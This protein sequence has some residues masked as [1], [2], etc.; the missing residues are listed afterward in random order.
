MMVTPIKAECLS[1]LQGIS[2][3]FFTR[4]GGVSTGIY[5]G[6]N[7][8]FGSADTASA[9]AENRRR[10]AAHLLSEQRDANGANSPLTILTLHQVHS[11]MA[12]SVT[13]TFARD[14]LPKADGLVTATRG[15]VIGVLAA[16]CGPVLFADPH[17]VVIG[18]AHAGWKGAVGG[19]LEATL[20]A[21]ERLGARRDHIRAAIGPCISQANYEVGDAFEAELLANQP[22]A[23]PFFVRR[24]ARASVH[25]DLPGYIAAHLTKAGVV[26]VEQQSFCTYAN[27]SLFFSFRR[28]THRKEVDYGRQI[29]AIV[30]T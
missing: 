13:G 4:E 3:G 21:M 2:H 16:D 14:A 29:S 23:S 5:A 7:C 20:A 30:L 9:V 18:A 10:A 1:G 25:F 15:L 24:G 17:A 26:T 6:L 11:A 27:E 22:D 28:A 19:I 12:V 8:G